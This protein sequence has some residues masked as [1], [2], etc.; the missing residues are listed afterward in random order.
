MLRAGEWTSDKGWQELLEGPLQIP[1]SLPQIHPNSLEKV[2]G[3]A[4]SLQLIGS[5]DIS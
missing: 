2:G 4:G 5:Q 1:K 3:L